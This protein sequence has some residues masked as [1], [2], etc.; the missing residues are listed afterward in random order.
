ML[1][2]IDASRATMGWGTGTEFY[3][4]RLIQALLALETRH[5]FRLYVNRPPEN[6]DL[7]T[8]GNGEYCVIPFPRLWTH[9][10]LALEVARRPPDVLF[11]PSHVLPLW[12]AVPA[13]A[14][15]HDLGYRA[16]PEAHPTRQRWYLDWSTRHNARTARIVLADSEATRD[17]LVRYY[18]ISRSKIVVAYPGF[19]RLRPVT[20]PGVIA[21]AKGRYAIPLQ[22]DYFLHIGTLQP[23]K[24]LERLVQAFSG[25][26]NAP[27][28]VR[29]VLAGKKGWLYEALFREVRRLG[30]EESV[31]FTGYIDQADKAALLSGALGYVFPSLWEGFGFPALEA[32]ACDT[33]L[34]CSRNASLP[35]VAGTGALFV[36]PMDVAGWTAAMTRLLHDE[37]LR[38]DL[39]ARGRHNRERFSWR[40][41]AEIALEVLERVANS[42]VN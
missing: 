27:R 23:R 37:E 29:L 3:S 31:T 38:S 24:N 18:R 36:D 21:A 22:A 7:F 42:G 30:L 9:V 5:R 35:E 28:E 20:D 40:T 16:F 4:V 1:I 2:G 34:I 12:T 15:V 33:P 39:V 26:E 41:T 6:R 17:D 8:G 11:V 13:V 25:L 14:T 19:E 32:Q 10:R